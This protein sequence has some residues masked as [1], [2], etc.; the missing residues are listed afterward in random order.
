MFAYSHRHEPISSYF[1]LY[2][3]F[4]F[5]FTT[6]DKPY[7]FKSMKVIVTLLALNFLI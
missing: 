5:F 4:F 1:D 2:E 3:V 6:T 7:I